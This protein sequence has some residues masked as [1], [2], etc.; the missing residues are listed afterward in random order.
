MKLMDKFSRS[1][2]QSLGTRIQ[3]MSGRNDCAFYWFAIA[4]KRRQV[5]ALQRFR[6]FWFLAL[7]CEHVFSYDESSKMPEESG[8]SLQGYPVMLPSAKRDQNND[9]QQS[10]KGVEAGCPYPL[11]TGE[12]GPFWSYETGGRVP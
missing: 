7:G 6:F 3:I 5:A 2:A 4:T 11:T 8:S 10:S 9:A 1:Q 12:R